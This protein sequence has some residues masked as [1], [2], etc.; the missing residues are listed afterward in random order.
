DSAAAGRTS[1]TVITAGGTSLNATIHVLPRPSFDPSTLAWTAR[2]PYPG[3]P[4]GIALAAAE[5]PDAT[6]L[7]ATLYTAGGAEP[8]SMTPD[9]GVYVAHAIV[10]GA[11]AD[12]RGR[13][14]RRC[15]PGQDLSGRWDRRARAS[16]ADR[17]HGKNRL[18]RAHRWLVHAAD[19]AGT[20]RLWERAGP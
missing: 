2:T 1:L 13:R 18:G 15:T 19:A 14:D 7:R 17:L 4:S 11:P 8:P 9:S 10:A 6:G 3:A 5:F 16:P 20:A 12:A